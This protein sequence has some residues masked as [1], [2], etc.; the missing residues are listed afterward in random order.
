MA[1]N[2]PPPARLPIEVIERVIDWVRD[3]MYEDDEVDIEDL[4]PIW[5]ACALTCR[6]MLPRSQYWL[7]RDIVLS[8]QSQADNLMD[9]IRQNPIVAKHT[10]EFVH[11]GALR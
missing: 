10:R 9:I 8:K 11:L 5:K 2:D 7:F 1:T 3:L 6:A 4:Y